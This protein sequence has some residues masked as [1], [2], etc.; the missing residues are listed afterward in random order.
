MDC[1]E[2]GLDESISPEEPVA[3]LAVLFLESRGILAAHT[4]SHV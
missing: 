3:V 2:L 1:R 4:T